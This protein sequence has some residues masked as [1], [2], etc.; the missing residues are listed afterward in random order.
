[1]KNTNNSSAMKFSRNACQHDNFIENAA[2]LNFSIMSNNFY[3]R[4]AISELVTNVLNDLNISLSLNINN[5][6]CNNG[7]SLFIDMDYMD[8][9]GKLNSIMK[10]IN[11]TNLFI[12]IL[13]KDY[14]FY[15]KLFC[16]GK[17]NKITYIFLDDPLSA[18]KEKIMMEL[19]TTSVNNTKKIE[20][21]KITLEHCIINNKFTK[22]EGEFIKYFKMGLSN[23]NIAKILNKSEK[24][25][26][27]QKRSAMKKIGVK[28]DRELFCKV[29][30]GDGTV[31]NSPL[32]STFP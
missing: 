25:I 4:T 11:F 15:K 19:E 14:V 5:K 13:R 31:A 30:W 3:I 6:Y 17:K 24:T 16:G 20:P 23:S 18:F 28:T 8:S 2:V 27:C 1:M 22:Q 12:I 29:W 9:L 7:G 32:G 10:K 26:S 21:S